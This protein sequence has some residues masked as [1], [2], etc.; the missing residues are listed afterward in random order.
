MSNR[1]QDKRKNARLQDVARVAGC[2]TGTA[3]RALTRPDMVS[4]DVIRRVRAAAQKLGYTPNN[5]AR[6]LRSRRTHIIGIV[7]PTLDHAIYAQLVNALENELANKGYS[8][9]VTTSEFNLKRELRQAQL[10]VERGSEGVVLVGDLH[11]RKLYE[12]IGIKKI[13]Y[14]NAYVYKPAGG[15]PCI[16]FDNHRATRQI[17]D[18]LISLGHA[19][20]GMIAGVTRDNDRARDRVAGL[21]DALRTHGLALAPARVVEQPYSVAAGREGMRMLAS[22]G[23]LPSAVICGSDVLAFGAVAECTAMGLRVP[24]D[25]SIVGFDDL[26]FAAHLNPPLTTMQVPAAEMGQRAANY[27]LARLHGET[28]ADCA[29]VEA[30][31]IVRGTTAA[32]KGKART[33]SPKAKR[34]NRKPA[35]TMP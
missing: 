5:A 16:G 26:E 2:S 32:L 22:R 21:R 1:L 8:L 17:A 13:P 9:L 6:S 12:F 19:D 28:P 15:H 25:I 10:L 20:I 30:R 31:L 7:I 3:S 11:D 4:A 23:A 35:A 34:Q 14:V 33:S 18:Y 27:L 24:D 29:E